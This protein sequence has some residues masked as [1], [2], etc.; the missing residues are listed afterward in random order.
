MGASKVAV[1]VLERVPKSAVSRAF[2]VVSDLELP[3]P[4]Q[5]VVNQAFARLAGIDMD[6]A[7]G[8][9]KEY[10]SLNAYFTRRL[11]EGARSLQPESPGALI[12]PVD[13]RVGAFGAV[14]SG[15]LLQAK[16]REYSLLDLVDSAEKADRFQGGHYITLYLSPRDYHRIHAPAAGRVD[17]I[18][19]I[20]GHLFPV[21]PFAVENV[22]ELF[23]VN[24]RL[25]TYLATETFGDVAVIK[26][27]ATCV[28]RITLSFQGFQTNQRFARRQEIDVLEEIPMAAGQE[29]AAFN[30]GSTVILL[31]EEEG[32]RFADSVVGGAMMR[33]GE[34]LGEV[35]RV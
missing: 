29:L 5:G 16:G 10:R 25:I 12:S 23:A 22:D 26:V 18:S 31:I 28:G 6:E 20:P 30:L 1:K 32:F 7:Q 15:T 17:R 8:P 24:E 11:K 35:G 13:G 2:G 21:N 34:V 3:R 27:G 33:V 4:V 9:P 14:E 19:Y